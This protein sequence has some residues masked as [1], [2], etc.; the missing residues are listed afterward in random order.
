MLIPVPGLPFERSAE[1]DAIQDPV[2][3]LRHFVETLPTPSALPSV[4]S[5][6]I[7]VLLQHA[8]LLTG[9][10]HLLYGTTLTSLAV[11]L[12][13]G[14]SHGG[15]FHVREEAQEEWFPDSVLLDEKERSAKHQRSVRLIR[16][17]REIGRK[18]C[19]AWS[20]WMHLPVVGKQEARWPG[21]KPG[22][23]ELTKG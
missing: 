23:E 11:S 7:R 22:I 1:E 10:S 9:S 20:W 15:G 4:I 17:L 16:P 21:T 12:I 14:V 8:A 5:S 3:S 19:G 13:S 18:E 6:L 2:V